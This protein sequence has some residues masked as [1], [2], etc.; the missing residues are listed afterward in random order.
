MIRL[1]NPTTKNRRGYVRLFKKP[2]KAF[3]TNFEES[4]QEELSIDKSGKVNF[5]I[6][7]KEIFTIELETG[8]NR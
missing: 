4:R 6:A 7:G 1:F 5:P 2:Q 3:R 8:Q